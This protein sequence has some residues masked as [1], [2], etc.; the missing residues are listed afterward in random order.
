MRPVHAVSRAQAMRKYNPL[1]AASLP[2]QYPEA[3]L[4]HPQQ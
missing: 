4:L 1:T 2:S 3:L